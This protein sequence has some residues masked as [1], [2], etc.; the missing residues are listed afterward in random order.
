M[1]MGFTKCEIESLWAHSR[2][3]F[4]NWQDT[5]IVLSC[6]SQT[7][8][9]HLKAMGERWRKYFPTCK[10]NPALT[11]KMLKYLCHETCG[12]RW[13]PKIQLHFSEWHIHVPTCSN[14]FQRFFVQA[15]M[16]YHALSSNISCHM[17]HWYWTI[18]HLDPRNLHANFEALAPQPN[19]C[20]CRMPV[21]QTLANVRCSANLPMS[22]KTFSLL[23]TQ[24]LG[25]SSAANREKGSRCDVSVALFSHRKV[26]QI[27]SH[28][29]PEQTNVARCLHYFNSNLQKH[30]FKPRLHAIQAAEAAIWY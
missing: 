21:P 16:F 11:W 13:D 9:K 5:S 14:M 2:R 30:S 22:H 17:Q 8:R 26:I 6:C 18:W 10:S 23:S 19:K 24:I 3:Y 28:S 20:S 1:V 25:Q 15:I 12:N 7:H 29:M 4:L 27:V